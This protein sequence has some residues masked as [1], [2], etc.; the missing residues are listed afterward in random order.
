MR[1]WFGA[2][3][4]LV[5]AGTAAHAH[6]GAVLDSQVIGRYMQQQ[7]QQRLLD[8][9]QDDRVREGDAL[10]RQVD[11]VLLR[12]LAAAYVEYPEA[13]ALRWE[14]RVVEDSTISAECY[15]DGRIL[16]SRAFAALYEDNDDALA[17]VL[18]HEMGHVL[19]RHVVNYYEAAAQRIRVIGLTPELLMENV[20]TNTALRMSLSTL[21]RHQEREADVVGVT[22][23]QAAGYRRD[24]AITVL[25]SFVSLLGGDLTTLSHDRPS[26]RLAA[27]RASVLG[28][29][30]DGAPEPKRGQK[31]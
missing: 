8:Y 25:H 7:S 18:A 24:G 5:L 26:V 3:V 2:V 17:F 11:R 20:D 16:L 27:L 4:G 19:M 22:L 28:A 10:A 21:S 31:P 15:P 13:A 30:A 1:A 6:A 12:L 29:N 23:A 14:A 9:E